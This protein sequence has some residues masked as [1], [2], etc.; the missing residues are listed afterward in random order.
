MSAQLKSGEAGHILLEGKVDFASAMGLRQ[1]LEKAVA[2]VQGTVTLDLAGVTH[3]NSVGLS[4]ILFVARIVTARDDQLR[5]VHLPDGL[6]SIARVCE[7]EDWL[8]SV[9]A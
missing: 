9:A 2:Q 4:L 8:T 5:V 1:E 3:A 7:L 6:L